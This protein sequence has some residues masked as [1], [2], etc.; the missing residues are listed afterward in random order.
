M[1][2]HWHIWQVDEV[3]ALVADQN[4]RLT[5]FCGGSRNFFKFLHPFDGVFVLEIDLDTLIRRL[6]QR[7]EDEFG[8]QQFERDLVVRLHRTEED[9]PQNGILIDATAPLTD[10]VNAIVRR[11]PS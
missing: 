11:S 8:A 1:P 3:R 10:V 7:A 5:F 4:E 9:V 6:E 2:S